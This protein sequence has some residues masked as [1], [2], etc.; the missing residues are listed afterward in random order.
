MKLILC[1]LVA[2]LAVPILTLPA[3]AQTRA[4]AEVQAELDALSKQKQQ[5]N[6]SLSTINNTIMEYR[7]Q[8]THRN[9]GVPFHQSQVEANRTPETN[10]VTIEL[11]NRSGRDVYDEAIDQA[12]NM[13]SQVQQKLSLVKRQIEKVKAELKTAS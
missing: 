4:K 12:Q 10:A 11:A 1:A 6:A 7:L 5:L 13:K 2:A 9:A 3:T 8:R